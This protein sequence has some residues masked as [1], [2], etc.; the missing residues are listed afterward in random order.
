MEDI[1]IKIKEKRNKLIKFILE[2]VFVDLVGMCRLFV[3]LIWR[4]IYI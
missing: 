2:V 1:L 3:E 4:L